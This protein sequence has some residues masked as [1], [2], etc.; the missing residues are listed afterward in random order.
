MEFAAHKIIKEKYL[1]IAAVF[2]GFGGFKN[3]H[4]QAAANKVYRQKNGR[5]QEKRLQAIGYNNGF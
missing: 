2:N 4:V 1:G 5:Y 3:I